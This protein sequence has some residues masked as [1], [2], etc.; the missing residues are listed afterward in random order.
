MRVTL[1]LAIAT[2]VTVAIKV[3]I[4][5]SWSSLKILDRQFALQQKI[6]RLLFKFLTT[7]FHE[8]CTKWDPV[9]FS[10]WA[11]RL[12][13]F[14]ENVQQSLNNAC[15]KVG[16][17]LC[18]DEMDRWPMTLTDGCNT[19]SRLSRRKIQMSRRMWFEE[20]I[21]LDTWI[22]HT[23]DVSI[24]YGKDSC[25][26]CHLANYSDSFS[27]RFGQISVRCP[28]LQTIIIEGNFY[29]M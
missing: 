12:A 2:F 24:L 10:K 11:K 21:L 26:R 3:A 5:L 25:N 23:S 19:R 16:Q 8:W 28:L 27:S 15:R 1:F 20:V 18:F 17:V 7:A 9:T 14:R 22:T 4:G 13:R 6:H 29:K